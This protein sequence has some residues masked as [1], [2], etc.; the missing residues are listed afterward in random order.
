[1]EDVFLVVISI[2]LQCHR[3][4]IIS[5]RLNHEAAK[6]SITQIE[7]RIELGIAISKAIQ[8][9]DMSL[10]GK[11]SEIEQCTFIVHAVFRPYSNLHTPHNLLDCSSSC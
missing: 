2:Q 7:P 5:A 1:M 8:R 3:Q 9:H 4:R 10:S 11:V 6:T